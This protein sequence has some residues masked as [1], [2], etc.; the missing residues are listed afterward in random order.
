MLLIYFLADVSSVCASQSE[1]KAVRF[2]NERKSSGLR[3]IVVLAVV[4]RNYKRGKCLFTAAL[5]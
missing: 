2:R 3:R 5:G 1:G 4:S